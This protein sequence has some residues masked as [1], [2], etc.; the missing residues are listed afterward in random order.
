MSFVP[1]FSLS[2]TKLIPKMD[3]VI[4]HGGNN[5]T[6]E[7]FAHGCPMLLMAL[8]GDQFDNMLDGIRSTLVFAIIKLIFVPGFV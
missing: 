3:L 2:Q 8:F 1:F 5:T 4:T 6:T 7:T